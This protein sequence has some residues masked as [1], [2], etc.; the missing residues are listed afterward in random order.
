MADID[1]TDYALLAAI[2]NAEQ[3]LWKK[4]LH[5]RLQERDPPLPGNTELSLQS[6]GRRINRLH[7][8]ELVDTEIVHPADVSQNLI[9]GY[10]LTDAG[11]RVLDEKRGEIIGSYVGSTEDDSTFIDQD[12]LLQMLD[13]EL[14]LSVEEYEALQEQDVEALR[15]FTALYHALHL[16]DTRIDDR[17]EAA[18]FDIIRHRRGHDANS[19]DNN[20]GAVALLQP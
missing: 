19:G 15:V 8:Q 13:D 20:A 12:I 6:V 16:V 11:R 4:R 17:T 3:P 10:T 2:V 14:D 7:E 9:I 1:E 18:F 5:T